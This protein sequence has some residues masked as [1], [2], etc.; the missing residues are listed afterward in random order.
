M[1]KRIIARWLFGAVIAMSIFGLI[2]P[3]HGGF[4]DVMICLGL[5]AGIVNLIET[6]K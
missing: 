1:K 3:P 4:R 6:F 2:I 5:V